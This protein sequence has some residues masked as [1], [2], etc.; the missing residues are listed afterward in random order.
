MTPAAFLSLLLLLPSLAR[1]AAPPPVLDPSAVDRSV[2]PCE[3]FYQYS[4]GTWLAA[5]P[6]PPDQSEWY[7]GSLLDEH[8]LSVLRAILAEAEAERDRSD[9]EARK[10]GDFYAACMDAPAVEAKGLS[11]LEPELA[12]IDAVRGLAGLPAEAARLQSI[13]AGVLFSFAP[14]QDYTDASRMIA[15]ADQGG[16]ALPDRGY[17]LEPGFKGDLEAYR[18]HVTRM[19]ELLGDAPPR[20][21]EE[22]DAA[23]A[24]ETALARASMSRVKR[25]VPKN[26]YHKMR[27]SRLQAMTPSFSWEAYLKAAGAPP[28]EVL[29]VTDPG[30]FKGLEKSL[31]TLSLAQWRSYLRWSLVNAYARELPARFVNEDFAFFGR[32]LSGQKELRPRWKRC[33]GRVDSEMGEALGRLYVEREFQP[34]SKARALQL[35]RAVE[36]AMADDIRGSGWMAARTKRRALGKLA[37]VGN[38]IGYPDKWRD[39]SLLVVRPDDAFGDVARA[40]AFDAARQLRKIGR[41]VDRGEWDMTPP[42]DNAYYDDQRNTLNFP[43]GYLQPPNFSLDA[44]TASLMG[45]F[46]ATLGHELTHGFDDEGRHYDAKGDLADWW[47][48]AD[49]RAFER[50]ADAFA[51]EYGAF[52]TV[53]ST[54]P[55]KVV[56][57]DGR[58]TLGENIADNGGLRLAWMALA[59]AGGA[60]PGPSADGWTPAQRFF[61]AYAQGWCENL[62]AA[63]ARE[64]A[65]SDEHA[66]GRWRVDGVV[67]NMPEF[68]A[69]FSCREGSPMA[70]AVRNRVW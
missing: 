34:A 2:D 21:A 41:P 66:T 42:T 69:A 13:G 59:R 23:L 61:L 54:D 70:P 47:T 40:E 56:R 62:T 39:Y 51:R 60:G 49:G 65:K 52:V 27:L 32:R 12:R 31:R 50:R 22:A 30:F 44:D 46:G 28:F 45:S 18:A 7:R 43:A 11:P 63:D 48:R 3:D 37:A 5:N 57:L 1:A 26:L 20:A 36:E 4:C 16:F 55:A 9:A 53:A 15:D 35:A 10:V 25:R 67:S 24:G 6:V 68:A 19:F 64:K 29:D 58:L 17:Y 8:T 33:V 14:E 38:K